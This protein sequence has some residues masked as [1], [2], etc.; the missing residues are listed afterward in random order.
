LALPPPAVVFAYV[1]PI[2]NTE[3]TLVAEHGWRWFEDALDEQNPDVWDLA[4][5][6]SPSIK[7]TKDC[8][9]F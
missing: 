5:S 3:A 8:K 9:A 7:F 6:E 2:T 1:V 4:R